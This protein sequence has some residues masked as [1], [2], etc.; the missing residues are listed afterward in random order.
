MDISRK[1]FCASMAGATVTLWLQGCGG[2]GGGYD[3]GSN[4]PPT[5]STACGAGV[6]NI[7]G[8]HG[9]TLTIL[10]ADLD[11]TVNKTYTL[12]AATT[13]GHIH[14]VSFTPTQLASMKTGGTVTVTSTTNVG[15]SH[16]VAASVASTCA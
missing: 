8:N 1:R 11:S 6:G 4:P 7:T 16:D 15:H 14:T 2:G 5:G 10:K 13:D 12:G 3:G 9:H